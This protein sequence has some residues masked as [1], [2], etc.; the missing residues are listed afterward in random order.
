MARSSC[1]L[2]LPAPRPWAAVGSHLAPSTSGNLMQIGCMPLGALNPS[3][4]SSDWGYSC[5]CGG[6]EWGCHVPFTA[7]VRPV[8][9]LSS[10]P[11]ACAMRT[12]R[13][14][15]P[16]SHLVPHLLGQ[17]RIAVAI[18]LTSKLRLSEGSDV[19]RATPWVR[20]QSWDQSCVLEPRPVPGAVPAGALPRVLRE[21]GSYQVDA[22]KGTPE[23]T[24]CA[25][26]WTHLLATERGGQSGTLQAVPHFQGAHLWLPTLDCL[27]TPS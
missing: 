14:F 6:G 20:W 5:V 26:A 17:V 11:A 3:F 24:A 4:Q 2:P 25:E 13:V 8:P 16:A 7:P 22:G 15:K 18:L 9:P 19:P 27:S 21:R 23:G 1:S 12:E 10:L